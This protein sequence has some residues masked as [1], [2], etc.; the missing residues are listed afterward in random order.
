MV[1]VHRCFVGPCDNNKRYPEKLLKITNFKELK[2]YC[3]PTKNEEKTKI[4]VNQQNYSRICSN[5]FLDRKATKR[6]VHPTPHNTTGLYLATKKGK[7]LGLK[8]R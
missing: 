1:R 3:F 2:W 6:N 4:W 5:H 7:L 8:E